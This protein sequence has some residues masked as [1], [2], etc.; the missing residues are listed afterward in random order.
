MLRSPVDA[1]VLGDRLHLVSVC[2]TNPLSQEPLNAAPLDPQ[3]RRLP[4]PG[5]PPGPPP[6]RAPAPPAPE[7]S[8]LGSRPSRASPV[9]GGA[10]GGGP[11]ASRV[12]GKSHTG[13]E[14]R[15]PR[16]ASGLR[17]VRESGND[18]SPGPGAH[19]HTGR[20]LVPVALTVS[21]CPPAPRS[22][23]S[24]PPPARSQRSPLQCTSQ[25]DRRPRD[26]RR[27]ATER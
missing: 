27:A 6:R 20:R 21:R 25:P 19:P 24:W 23:S 9:S 11:P 26:P 14:L 16:G 12:P 22:S 2:P 4:P 7:R 10:R 18:G 8:G 13:A 1:V 17:E 5:S 15:R 3:Q